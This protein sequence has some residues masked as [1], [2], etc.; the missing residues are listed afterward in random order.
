MRTSRSGATVI[1]IA[2]PPAS[3]KLLDPKG[4][5]GVIGRY[6]EEDVAGHLV[7]AG[8]EIINRKRPTYTVQGR[9]FSPFAFF[10]AKL[11]R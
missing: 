5:M 3:D 7:N 2:F 9:V 11:I 1:S 8:Y 6:S 10:V 4:N